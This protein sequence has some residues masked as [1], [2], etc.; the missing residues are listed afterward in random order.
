MG[1]PAALAPCLPQGSPP[2]RTRH[3]PPRPLAFAHAPSPWNAVP[4]PH[5]VAPASAPRM[6]HRL[7][8]VSSGLS[9]SPAFS[10]CHLPRCTCFTWWRLCPCGSGP[11]LPPQSPLL[12]RLV[13][14]PRHGTSTWPR[15]EVRGTGPG[16]L[17]VK[18]GSVF[19]SIVDGAQG[20]RGCWSP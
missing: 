7:T 8:P 2:S 15:C 13:H 20:S 19:G 11:P 3:V 9:L 12:P 16:E 6:C 4:I 18:L 5:T 17:Q 10:S 1:A 14:P